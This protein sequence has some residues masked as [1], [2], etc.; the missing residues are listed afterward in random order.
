MYSTGNTW[1]GESWYINKQPS[2]LSDQ[3]AI[4]VD[5]FCLEGTQVIKD[6][7]VGYETGSDGP[8]II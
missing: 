1:K 6:D 3:L 2:I 5:R 4:L 8:T 7:K